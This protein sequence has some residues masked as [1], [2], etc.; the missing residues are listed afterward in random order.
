MKQISPKINKNIN[1]TIDLST[2]DL[3]NTNST[4]KN[5]Q[6]YINT[7]GRS[8]S[9]HFN[10][11]EDITSIKVSELLYILVNGHNDELINSDVFKKNNPDLVNLIQKLFK[12]YY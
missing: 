2:L 5:L 3:S 12:Y 8:S 11:S 9:G 7:I 6:K 1:F 10:L 4:Y